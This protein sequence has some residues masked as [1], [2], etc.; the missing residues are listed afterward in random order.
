MCALVAKR[1]NMYMKGVRCRL[2]LLLV[3]LQ[4]I[5]ANAFR[6]SSERCQQGC[7][8]A[9]RQHPNGKM[10]T[11]HNPPLSSQQQQLGPTP[12]IVWAR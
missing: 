7:D 3:L 10:Y 8:F 5:A 1:C 12:N 9:V 6:A 4:L 2:A 11:V